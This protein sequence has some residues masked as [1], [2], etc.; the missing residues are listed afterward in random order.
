MLP[1]RY[2]FVHS[3]L[4]QPVIAIGG[5]YVFIKEASFDLNGRALLYRVGHA[6]VDSACCG[7][8]GLSYALVAGFI[9]HGHVRRDSEG[10]FISEV[11]PISDPLLQ[12]SIQKRIMAREAVSQVVFS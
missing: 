7:P 2:E 5:H 12:L 8:G 3:P 1:Q 10:H 6:G 4:N 11:E 9:V